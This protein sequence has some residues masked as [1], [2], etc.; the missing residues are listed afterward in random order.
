MYA[1]VNIEHNGAT[2]RP[3]QHLPDDLPGLDE[4]VANGS[5]ALA[6]PTSNVTIDTDGN[7]LTGPGV[8]PIHRFEGEV[9]ADEIDNEPQAHPMFAGTHFNGA[10]HREQEPHMYIDAGE[11][12]D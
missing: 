4:L 5:A 12:Y 8:H 7:V 3:G 2:Y 9:N 10:Q 1:Q 11:A 6:K